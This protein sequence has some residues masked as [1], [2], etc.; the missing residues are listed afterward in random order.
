[1]TAEYALF[2]LL[3]ALGL[4]IILWSNPILQ[5]FGYG[6]ISTD[7][8]LCTG[9]TALVLLAF[10]LL[11]HAFWQDDFSILYVAENSHT[12]LPVW[13]KLS[14]VWGAHEGSF[15]LWC[16]VSAAWMLALA[17]ALRRG[18]AA[19]LGYAVPTMSVLMT[20]FL[21]F[22]LLS[23]SP[24]ERAL[25]FVPGEGNDLNP[26]LQDLALIVHPP[27]LYVGYVGFAVPFSMAVSV[28]IHG[29]RGRA[30]AA[31][32]QPFVLI[33]WIFLTLGITLGSWWAY[34][35]LGWGGWWFWDPVEN[36]SFMPWL[37]GT[38][39]LHSLAAT[40]LRG[41]FPGWTLLLAIL[42]CGLSLLGAFLVRSGILTSVH[43]FALDPERGLFVLLLLLASLGTGL[44]LFAW[45]APSFGAAARYAF[46][47]REFWVLVNNAL[48][49]VST[50]V[51]FLGTLYPL[52]HEF[53]TDEKVSV[54]PPYFN[55]VF[56]PL[57]LLLSLAMGIGQWTRWGGQIL[58]DMRQLGL[59]GLGA[60]GLGLVLPLLVTGTVHPVA[61]GS[62]GMGSWL[63]LGVVAQICSR[64]RD[65]AR[66]IGMWVAHTGFAC[67][68]A[69][70]GLTSQYS[71]ERDLAMGVGESLDVGGYRFEFQG[72]E[73]VAGANYLADQARVRVTATDAS[74]EFFTLTP[75]KRRYDSG[76]QIMTEAAIRPSLI[77]DV[78]LSLG[79]RIKDGRWTLRIQVKPFVRWIWLGALIMAFGGLAHILLMRR[80]PVHRH[81]AIAEVSAD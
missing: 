70:I 35:E 37:V 61:V 14:A 3:L 34:Y 73:E 20:G 29:P 15:L 49:M 24:F 53:L 74:G 38:A 48:L 78:Y 19:E 41:V 10:V 21:L 80:L 28:L 11:S 52:L 72:V 2:A 64:P 42:G 43:A 68:L 40:R 27:M 60:L 67:A 25:P 32:M 46:S 77:E 16:L 17:L 81:E 50:A 45:R 33:P 7:V 23:S 13:F 76:G 57:M 30:F 44:A 31:P 36:A 18:A 55:L 62:I 66:R 5:R 22:M 79:T 59:L 75:E 51:V 26:L 9:V 4:S 63:V 71:V 56:V 12:S 39:L 54:G 6:R 69:G 47:A 58:P 65:F 1:M 8:R